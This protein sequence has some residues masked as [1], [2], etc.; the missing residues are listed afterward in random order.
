[1][2][3]TSPFC[4]RDNPTLC[5]SF[6]ATEERFRSAIGRKNL[7][8]PHQSKRGSDNM[9]CENKTQTTFGDWAQI[10]QSKA[11]PLRLIQPSFSKFIQYLVADAARRC[12]CPTLE[13]LCSSVRT[14]VRPA[15]V[16][17]VRA[18]RTHPVYP[19]SCDHHVTPGFDVIQ[20]RSGSIRSCDQFASAAWLH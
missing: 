10:C 8:S 19:L 11:F 15:S 12:V 9:K 13:M 2:L 5:S 6:L 4:Q 1:M 7:C 18:R 17:F 3:L 16:G 20:F 14:V